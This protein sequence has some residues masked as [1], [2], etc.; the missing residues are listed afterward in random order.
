MDR[1]VSL[2]LAK[3][4]LPKCVNIVPNILESPNFT[5]PQSVE[6]KCVAKS[7]KTSGSFSN[8]SGKSAKFVAMSDREKPISKLQNFSKISWYAWVFWLFLCR[9][10]WRHVTIIQKCLIFDD[11][12]RQETIWQ[13]FPMS[14]S[15]IGHSCEAFTY[16][17]GPN[18]FICLLS[19][20][21]KSPAEIAIMGNLG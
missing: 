17:F 2:R 14:C 18:M 21:K 6:W 19:A 10:V 15:K 7:I 9:V 16:L 12:S 8:V 1:T 20:N 4:N 5:A 3:H 13:H 11:L